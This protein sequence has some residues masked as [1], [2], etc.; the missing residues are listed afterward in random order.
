MGLPPA[1]KNQL[2]HTKHLNNL[3]KE[4]NNG[5][6]PKKDTP[7]FLHL[8]FGILAEN[9]GSDAGSEEKVENQSDSNN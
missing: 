5:H 2:L 3:K 6:T 1:L 4:R 7:P 9:H 8:E